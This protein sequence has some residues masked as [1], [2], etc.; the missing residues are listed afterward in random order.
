[1][2]VS[3]YQSIGVHNFRPQFQKPDLFQFIDNLSVVRGSHSLR[4]GF[5]TRQ[6][7]NTFLDSNRTV[8][9]YTFNGSFTTEALADLLIGD[10]Y[11][12]DANTQAVVEQLQRSYAGYLQDDWKVARNLT[13]NLGLR[14]EYTTPYYAARPNMNINFD[15]K[16]GQL[17]FAKTPTD[18]T[19]NPAQAGKW[20]SYAAVLTLNGRAI[21]SSQFNINNSNSPDAPSGAPSVAHTMM[22]VDVAETGDYELRIALAAP[23]QITLTSPN[24]ELRRNIKPA[25]K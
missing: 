12:F 11:Q 5:E 7:N 1:M 6:K 22:I 20:N 23:Q 10:V 21:A 2:S 4:A 13:V 18:Y 8:P 15:F 16:T 14:Y 17:V 3:S 19:I 9:A 25:A 24:V